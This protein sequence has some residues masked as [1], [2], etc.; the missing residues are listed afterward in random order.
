MNQPSIT[1]RKEEIKCLIPHVHHHVCR[2]DRYLL[3]PGHAQISFCFYFVFRR[4]APFSVVSR[5]LWWLDFLLVS[6]FTRFLLTFGL[7]ERTSR[8]IAII[9]NGRYSRENRKVQHVTLQK[10]SDLLLKLQ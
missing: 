5:R 1:F 4:C 10:K 6:V 8:C 9:T 2:T 3:L 7:L